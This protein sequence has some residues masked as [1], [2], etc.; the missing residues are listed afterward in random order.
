MDG[1]VDIV[2]HYFRRKLGELGRFPRVETFPRGV[3]YHS[4][5][6]PLSPDSWTKAVCVPSGAKD[7][8]YHS[9]EG[10]AVSGL[11]HIQ[12]RHEVKEVK[13]VEDQIMLLCDVRKRVCDGL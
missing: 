1:T 8:E 11:F 9:I 6:V 10:G 5:T 3:H 2:A 13:A 7:F 4:L 12:V